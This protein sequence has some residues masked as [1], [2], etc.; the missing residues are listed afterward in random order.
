MLIYQHMQQ[1]VEQTYA[2]GQGQGQGEGQGEG[3]EN[4]QE[5]GQ[6]EGQERGGNGDKFVTFVKIGNDGEDVYGN[7]VL[8]HYIGVWLMA[9]G[10]MEADTKE[11]VLENIDLF[12]TSTE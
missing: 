1:Y 6:G 4:G 9:M 5:N 8:G 12:F 10:Y 11:R 7:R 3:Q 2:S